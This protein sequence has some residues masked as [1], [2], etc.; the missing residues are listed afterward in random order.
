YTPQMIVNGEK[1]VV[2]NRPLDLAEMLISAK[3]TAPKAS[4]DIAR[5]DDI[6]TVSA[7]ALGAGV[8]PADI[9]VIR[10]L[11][12]Q[13]QKIAKGENAGLSQRYTHIVTDWTTPATWDGTDRFDAEFDITGP[14]PV[15]VL[16]QTERF[17]AIL[18]AARIK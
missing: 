12:E 15:V 10:Y 18:A 4:V 8:G 17:G 11:P 6:L 3:F 9:H 13:M 2:G 14:G 1:D 7:Q 5:V 16:V